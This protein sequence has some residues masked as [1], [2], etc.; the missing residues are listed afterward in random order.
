MLT[1]LLFISS[2]LCL[3]VVPDLFGQQ[4]KVVA[5]TQNFTDYEFVN[6]ELK[7]LSP[8]EL[9]VPVRSGVPRFQVLEQSVREIHTSIPETKATVLALSDFE[10]PLIQVSQPG[11]YRGKIISSVSVNI[12]RAGKESSKILQKLHLRVYKQGDAIPASSAFRQVSLAD[13][14]LSAGKWYK[15]PITKNGIYQL[16]EEYLTELGLELS[17]VNPQHIQLWG[18]DGYQLPEANSEPTSSFKQIPILVE[19]E[20]DGTF[21]NNDRILFFANSPHKI[22]KEGSEYEHK[23]HPYSNEKYVFLTI[24]QSNGLRLNPQNTNLSP[25]RTITTFRDFIWKDEELHKSEEG[26]RSG[27]FWLGQRFNASAK[28]IETSIFQDTLPGIVSG[29][30]VKLDGRLV[31]RSIQRMYFDIAFNNQEVKRYSITRIN[32]YN[33]SDGASARVANINETLNSSIIQNG[34]INITATMDHNESNSTGFIDWLNISVER[35]LTAINNRLYFYS[36]DDGA[37]NEIGR[38]RINGFSSQP[39][40]MDVT[41][42][43]T[44]KL[45]ESTSSGDNYDVLYYTGNDLQFIAQSNFYIPQPGVSVANQNLHGL[46]YFPD[47]II[48]TSEEFLQSAQELAAYRETRDG[49]ASVI[50]TQN[51]VFNEFSNGASDP[52]ALRNFVKYLWDRALDASGKLPEYLLLFGD[53]TFD[54]KGIIEDS[55]TNHVLT[56]QT[57][58]SLSRRNSFATDDFFAFMDD[59][60]GDIYDN[61]KTAPTAM[62]DIGVGRISAQTKQ[63]AAIAVNKIK[64]YE[65]PDNTGEWQNLF[66]FTADD[67]FPQTNN[68]DLHVINA[69]GTAERMDI[70]KPGLRIKKIYEFTYPSEITGSGRKVPGATADFIQS[71]N[72]G[73][74]VIN[75]SGHGNEQTLSDESLFDSNLIPSL[76]NEDKLTVFVTATCQFGRYDDINNQ[77]GAEKLIFA[78]KGGAVASFT[79][80]RVVVTSGSISN[81]TNYGLNVGLSQNMVNS[82]QQKPLRFGDI[83][84]NTKNTLINGRLIVESINSK[85]FIFLGDPA[86]QFRLPENNVQLTSINNFSS[87]D[88]DTTLTI[89]ALDR[90]QIQGQITDHANTPLTNYSGEATIT[91]FDASRTVKLPNY[92]F[93]TEGNCYL[94]NCSYAVERDIL[95]KGKAAITNGAYTTEFIVP[96]DIRFTDATGRIVTFADTEGTTAGGSFTKVNFNGVNPDAENDGTGPQMDVFLNNERFVNGNLVNN[97]PTLIIELDDESGINTTGTGVGHE[98]IAT[99]DTKPQ[100]SFVLNDFYEG[101]LND[102]TQGRI[103]YP[104]DQLPE[105]SYTLKVRAWD[106]HNN[107]SEKEIF[108]EV[109]SDNNLEVRNIYNFPNPMNNA[110][111]FTFEHNQPGNPLDVSVRIYTLSGKP[112][113]HIKESLLT[114]SSYASISWDGRDRDYDRLGNGTY[115]YVLR[116]AANTPKGRKT[117]EK[118]EKLVI[119]R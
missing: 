102:F 44:P 110:T 90:L 48:I 108:F 101:T 30:P 103:E 74:L 46:D 111:K 80:T 116:V 70:I 67:N 29:T 36:P 49:F 95:F 91:I 51:Q 98:I 23:L 16:T 69:D 79:T 27:R 7:V 52:A 26:I 94:E 114:T 93:V 112:V 59:D 12:A 62:V 18:T 3:L 4:L 78:A 38:Y 14:P 33:D 63:E 28:G 42:P 115:I 87:L 13:H 58:E 81:R 64:R 10:A 37:N 45:L 54:Y 60:E 34:I 85:K 56:Y 47:Y 92:E 9:K 2:L 22:I 43:T 1:R 100:Q 35:S 106:V 82:Q 99:I 71:I 31:G 118:I 77:S 32:K 20:N 5:E 65:N 96:K 53:T 117:T 73:T 19:G 68:R 89:R 105:G 109:A 83:Y 24:A 55:Y 88:E 17:T 40:V 61:G 84:R 97:S 15:I 76:T 39:L 72:D 57:E 113:Q 41:D 86:G 104:L 21:N 66:T 75:Y 25:S 11:K 119:I 107:P 8:Y 50:A 6:D